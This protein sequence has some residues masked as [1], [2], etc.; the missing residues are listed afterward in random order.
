MEDL[1]KTNLT[2]GIITVSDRSYLGERPDASGPLLRDR[3]VQQGW[4]VARQ[5]VIPDEMGQI[6]A[7]LRSWADSGEMDVI[8]TTG[9]TG[10][11][12][13]DVTPEATAAVVDREIPGIG[14]AMRA[15]SL[16][17]TAHAML[18]RGMA[19]VRSQT[20]ILNLPGSPKG[21]LENLDVVLP[22]II[23]AVRLVQADPR[24]EAGHQDQT[25]KASEDG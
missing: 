12:P 19:G 10:L 21:A 8:L 6:S 15:A 25:V 2:L 16:Q 9:G 5:A 14:E 18:S 13:R 1:N 20:I 24:A 17:I 4:R 7:T 23:H 11:S 3:V 22:V